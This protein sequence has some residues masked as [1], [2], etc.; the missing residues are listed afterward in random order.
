MHKDHHWPL[1]ALL[2][3]VLERGTEAGYTQKL[4]I[5]RPSSEEEGRKEGVINT[6]GAPRRFIAPLSFL[7]QLEGLN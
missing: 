6:I 2:V 3:D 4:Q 5:C 7:S 1:A